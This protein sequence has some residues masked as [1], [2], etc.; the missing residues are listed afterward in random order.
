MG[1][2]SSL[3]L[4]CDLAHMLTTLYCV[5]GSQHS[6]LSDFLSYGTDSC[7]DKQNYVV[8][9]SGKCSDLANV[10]LHLL[11]ALYLSSA[12]K[13]KAPHDCSV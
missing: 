3:H 13:E 6:F 5:V 2:H 8:A 7:S 10:V 11:N 9:S 4:V 12:P 1:I